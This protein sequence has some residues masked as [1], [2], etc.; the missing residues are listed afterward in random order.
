MLVSEIR[1]LVTDIWEPVYINGTPIVA[2]RDGNILINAYQEP[3]F[4]DEVLE[5]LEYVLD[6]EDFGIFV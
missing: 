1:S 4:G 3:M 2:I 6:D 5:A